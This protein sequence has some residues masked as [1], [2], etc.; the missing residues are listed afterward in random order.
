AKFF[1]FYGQAEEIISAVEC[2]NG[3]YHLTMIDGITE[4]IRNDDPVTYGEKGVVI[5]SSLHNYSMPLIRYALNDYT[6]LKEGDCECGCSIPMIYP[7][8]TKLEDFII[9]PDGKIISP[10][11]LTF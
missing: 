5:A 8:E 10:S 1:G 3:N 2:K 4:I 6:G 9:T 7:I 11:L